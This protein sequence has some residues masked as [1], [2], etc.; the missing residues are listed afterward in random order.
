V[1]SLLAAGDACMG[2]SSLVTGLRAR[3]RGQSRLADTGRSDEHDILGLGHELELGEGADLA[4]IDAGLALEREGLEGALLAQARALDA[5][6]EYAATSISSCVAAPATP[7]DFLVG[8]GLASASRI[9]PHAAS[10]PA[11][12]TTACPTGS[13]PR[14]P[15]ISGP[16]ATAGDGTM[17][18][19]G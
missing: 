15:A 18:A 3:R 16:R 5:P 13:A 17:T 11:R 8:S 12:I 7:P 1:S 14:A 6:G 10:T 19:L 9:A 4:L 2:I